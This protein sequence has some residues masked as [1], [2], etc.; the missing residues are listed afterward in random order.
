MSAF[1]GAY[2]IQRCIQRHTPFKP[3]CR[4]RQRGRLFEGFSFF[5]VHRSFHYASK[6]ALWRRGFHSH[7]MGSGMVIGISWCLWSLHRGRYNFDSAPEGWCDETILSSYT[8]FLGQLHY[9]DTQKQGDARKV[10]Y[11]SL[12][13][14]PPNITIWHIE[15]LISSKSPPFSSYVHNLFDFFWFFNPLFQWSHQFGLCLIPRSYSKDPLFTFPAARCPR[16]R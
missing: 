16:P 6:L 10:T 9:P 4:Y 13:E 1:W 3:S 2:F 15:T 11:R 14:P 12:D 7:K 8:A 5:P